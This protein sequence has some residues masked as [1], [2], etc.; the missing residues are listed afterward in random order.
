MEKQADNLNR[1]IGWLF[2]GLAALYLLMSL[3]SL[4]FKPEDIS[5]MGW[6]VN[7]LSLGVC[8]VGLVLLRRASS[9]SGREAGDGA[10]IGDLR[11]RVLGILDGI[12]HLPDGSDAA[13]A[14]IEDLGRTYRSVAEALARQRGALPNHLEV[15]M[16]LGDAMVATQRVWTTLADSAPAHAR[17]AW[18]TACE[19]ATRVRHLLGT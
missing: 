12:M 3:V 7:V 11:L 9:T 14:A 5:A 19:H 10:Q 8:V 6:V 2:F 13:R 1:F 15:Q 4:R 17:V 16:G 18:Q